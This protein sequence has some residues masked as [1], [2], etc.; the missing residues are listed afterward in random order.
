MVVGA[1]PN[2]GVA[3]AFVAEGIP[4]V[5]GELCTWSIVPPVPPSVLPVPPTDFPIGN[6][7]LKSGKLNVVDPSPTPYAVDITENKEAYVVLLT[8][9]PSHKRNPSGE[10]APPYGNTTPLVNVNGLFISITLF[11]ELIWLCL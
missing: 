9:A 7:C 6:R 11:L 1:D 8:A 3:A 5:I 4:V 10:A 2:K